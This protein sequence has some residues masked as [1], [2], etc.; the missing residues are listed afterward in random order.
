MPRSKINGIGALAQVLALG[1]LSCKRA[2]VIA[3]N[4]FVKECYEI[5]R[6]KREDNDKGKVTQSD[7]EHGAVDA[8]AVHD[9]DAVHDAALKAAVVHDAAAVHDEAAVVVAAVAPADDVEYGKTENG[10]TTAT[11]H[12]LAMEATT[13]HDVAVAYDDTVSKEQDEVAAAALEAV[14]AHDVA[15][16]YDDI[17]FKAQDEAA[18]AATMATATNQDDKAIA[19]QGEAPA[20]DAEQDEATNGDTTTTP[21]DG[22]AAVTH[23][24]VV[25]PGDMD[26]TALDDMAVVLNELQDSGLVGVV[27]VPSRYS[28]VGVDYESGSP[29]GPRLAK[30]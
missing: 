14:A 7:K 24:V 11:A 6:E 13:A 22:M 25:L 18:A 3:I 4:S 9:A 26:H 16:V 15:V 23:S 20:V 5:I 12:D 21:R 28:K 29:H 30:R 10:D 8:A 1:R 19:D 27:D 2:V 17:T